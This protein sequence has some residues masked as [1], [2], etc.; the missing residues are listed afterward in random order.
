MLISILSAI[1]YKLIVFNTFSETQFLFLLALCLYLVLSVSSLVLNHRN[2]RHKSV[3]LAIIFAGAP[4]LV[5]NQWKQGTI[6]YMVCL[7]WIFNAK[8][9]GFEA[10][11]SFL[12]AAILTFVSAIMAYMTVD[13]LNEKKFN[14]TYQKE[15]VAKYQKTVPLLKQGIVP[16]LDT[17]ILMHDLLM[18]VAYL[19]DTNAPLVI[20]K[21]VFNELDGLKKGTGETRKRAQL[22]FDLLESFQEHG[23]LKLLDIPNRTKLEK[24]QLSN[25]AD[26]KI[27]GSYLMDIQRNNSKLAFL[28]NDKGARIIARQ[29]NMPIIGEG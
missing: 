5:S 14:E 21:Q 23:R 9:L 10:H 4:Q 7:L 26:D 2:D 8:A 12:G 13:G 6:I 20:S 16:A 25:S 24:F 29:V 28:S 17:N 3:W 1:I 18:L 27:I 19:R 15:A 11:Q 22:A